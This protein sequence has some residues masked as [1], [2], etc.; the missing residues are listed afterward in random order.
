MKRDHWQENSNLEWFLFF[1]DDG[2][3]CA[4]VSRK[5][6]TELKTFQKRP[7]FVRIK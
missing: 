7:I 4:S 5:W 6:S 2:F 3:F 1:V